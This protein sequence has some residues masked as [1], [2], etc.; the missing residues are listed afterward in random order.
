M[1]PVGAGGPDQSHRDVP[2]RAG[3][4]ALGAIRIIRRAGLRIPEDISII[5]IDDHPLAAL[6]DLTTVRQPVSDQG[7]RAARILLDLLQGKDDVDTAVTVPTQ[8]V[9]R[10]T[11][12]PPGAPR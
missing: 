8:L 12:A 9:V 7:A 11:T 2:S 4:V 6:A 1:V 5:G 10:R 3:K